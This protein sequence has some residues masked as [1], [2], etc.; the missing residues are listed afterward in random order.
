MQE[1]TLDRFRER[2]IRWPG[3][4]K[5]NGLLPP[6]VRIDG[7]ENITA[8]PRVR[9]GDPRA[10]FI[11]HLLNRNYELATDSVVQQRDFR[12]RFSRSL[13]GRPIRGAT[14]FAPGRD[15]VRLE[16]RQVPG[17]TE[18]RVPELGLWAILRLAR[19]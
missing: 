9:P 7:A 1:A 15:P 17:G 18:V 4:E 12:I 14:L 10:P 19:T 6:L 8:V 13:F 16:V 11:C 5:L 2:L 3:A